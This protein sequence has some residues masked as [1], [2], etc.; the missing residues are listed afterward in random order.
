MEDGGDTRNNRAKGIGKNSYSVKD[1]KR[2]DDI[3]I[4]KAMQREQTLA[5]S[6]NGKKQEEDPDQIKIDPT[7]GVRMTRKIKNKMKDKD[8][9]E[10]YD[11]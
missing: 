2:I 11:F 3:K 9:D 4:K 7:F 5:N 1:Q 6:K 8:S 10:D